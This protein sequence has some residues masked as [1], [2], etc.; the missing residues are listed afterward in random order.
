MTTYENFLWLTYNL[1][2]KYTTIFLIKHYLNDFFMT[3]KDFVSELTAKSKE[4]QDLM[5]RRMPVIVGQL[6]VSHFK[7]NFRKSGFVD[8]GLQPWKKSRR[9]GQGKGAGS[10]YKTLLSG[11]DH[12]FGSVSYIPSDAAVL[13]KN[14]LPYASIHNEG[15]QVNTHPTVTPKM[16]KFA[17]AKYYGALGLKKGE[18]VPESIPE[19]AERWRR[20]A[21]TKKTKLNIKFEMPK[22]QFIGE[23]KELNDKICN[24]LDAEL[25]KIWNQQ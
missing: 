4:T 20:L 2:C 16:K 21:L 3:L 11:R 25:E 23:S 7:D 10:N 5:R 1:R 14:D 24:K 13:I 19:D 17:W 8:N 9:I 18:K 6:A 15:G 22:R 12:L